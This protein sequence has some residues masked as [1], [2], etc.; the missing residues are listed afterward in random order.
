MS[1]LTVLARRM[2]THQRYEKG[3]DTIR[4][5]VWYLKGK[6]LAKYEPPKLHV[7][8][9]CYGVREQNAR[10]AAL[11]SEWGR[12]HNLTDYSFRVHHFSVSSLVVVEHNRKCRFYRIV[13]RLTFE[14]AGGELLVTDETGAPSSDVLPDRVKGIPMIRIR[15]GNGAFAVTNTGIFF[16]QYGANYYLRSSL[17][18]LKEKT[19]G[20][21]LY[22]II[23]KASSEEELYVLLCLIRPPF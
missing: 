14:P 19:R 2:L 22:P 23:G 12:L 3:Y 1:K 16:K 15:C 21:W 8:N 6:L 11:L 7:F 13:E 18:A 4:D 10:I 9:P 20:S 5:G 17:E